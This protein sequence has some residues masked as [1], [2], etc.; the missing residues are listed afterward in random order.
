MENWGLIAYKE[1]ALMFEPNETSAKAQQQVTMVIA[2]EL[3]HQW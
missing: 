2:H 1:T 3:A